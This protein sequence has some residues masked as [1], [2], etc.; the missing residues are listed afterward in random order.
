MEDRTR[1]YEYDR[2]IAEEKEHYAAIEITDR[3]TE[4]GV[5]A[6]D[7][8]GHYWQR[9]GSRLAAAGFGDL[10]TFLEHRNRGLDRPL[11]ILSL[12]SGYCGHEL[13]LAENLDADHRLTCTD[14][15]PALFKKAREVAEQKRLRIDFEEADLNFMTVDPGAYDLI[16]AHASL[17]HVINLEHLFDQIA[18]GLAPHSGVFHLVEVVGKNRKLIWDENEA[19]ANRMLDALPEEVTRGVRLRVE[20]AAAEGM[21][22]VRQEDILPLLRERFEPLFECAHGAFMRFICTDSR[23]GKLLDPGDLQLRSYLDLLIDIDESTV[24]NRLLRPLE[25]WG[26][27]RP[28]G[29]PGD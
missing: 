16:F 3:L 26:V 22:G 20:E 28:R 14:I 13:Q 18:A 17:H 21:E 4:G 10:A 5:H 29:G 2:L 25:I 23:L 9:I 19:F 12:G 11:R 7:S 15:N 1:D 24:R 27:Y 6:H 8:W